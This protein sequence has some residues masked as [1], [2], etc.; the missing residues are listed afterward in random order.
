[1]EE[2]ERKEEEDAADVA[3]MPLKKNPAAPTAAAT[4]TT[5]EKR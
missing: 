5:V 2:V 1:M 4:A 3:V